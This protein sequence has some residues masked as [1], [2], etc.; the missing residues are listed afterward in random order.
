MHKADPDVGGSMIKNMAEMSLYD[1]EIAG[2]KEA[3]LPSAGTF[4]SGDKLRVD[5]DGSGKV[6]RVASVSVKYGKSG[7]FYGF[8]GQTDKYEKFHPEADDPK[9]DFHERHANRAGRAGHVTG[10]NDKL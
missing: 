3:Y 7:Q 1:T 5:R 10:V 4:P 9:S 6:E 8:P 2:E